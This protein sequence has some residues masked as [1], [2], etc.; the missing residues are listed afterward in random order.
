LN[1]SDGAMQF[2]FAWRGQFAQY[3]LGGGEAVTFV[4]EGST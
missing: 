1:S 4:W 3:K 2:N